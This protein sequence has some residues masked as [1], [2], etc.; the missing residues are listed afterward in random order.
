MKVLIQWPTG[1]VEAVSQEDATTVDE[2]VNI[3][4]GS[5]WEV[6]QESGVKVQQLTEEEWEDCQSG[7]LAEYNAQIDAQLAQEPVEFP[8]LTQTPDL[9]AV[10]EQM[11]ALTT[12]QAPAL[13]TE[14]VAAV[15]TQQVAAL[16]T[17]QVAALG[18]T[19]K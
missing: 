4:F 19:T 18:T 8:E 5:A 17:E 11:S 12:E 14:Q 15:S 6:A 1:K 9:V 2:F 10:T 16:T 7:K 13:T 3:H